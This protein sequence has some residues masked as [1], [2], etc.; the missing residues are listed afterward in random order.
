MN[1]SNKNIYLIAF[2]LLLILTL[3]LCY[4]FLSISYSKSS[5]RL[6]SVV[7]HRCSS[8]TRSKRYF[9]FQF[10]RTKSSFYHQIK[11]FIEKYLLNRCDQ[12]NYTITKNL[13]YR[14]LSLLHLLIS[15]FLIW[16]IQKLI[17]CF[18]RSSSSYS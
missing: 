18:K 6:F 8:S 16:Q 14:F 13:L 17:R 4:Y 10:H 12:F 7:Y 11:D 15:F 5:Q 3:S 2:L 9:T 1:F